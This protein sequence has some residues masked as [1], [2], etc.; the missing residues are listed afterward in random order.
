VRER[1]AA[2]GGDHFRSF[3]LWVAHA[4]HAKDHDL[5]AE[6]VEGCEIETGLG[7][8]DRNLID[9]RARRFGQEGV[10][11]GFVAGGVSGSVSPMLITPNITVVSPRPSRVLSPVGL[12]SRSAT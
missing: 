10:T 1:G 12:G 6:G 4:D 8:F 7:G 5:V 9:P 2:A 3:R 11:V